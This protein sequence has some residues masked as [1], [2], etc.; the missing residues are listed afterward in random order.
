V[1]EKTLPD[2][3]EKRTVSLSEQD[4]D[5]LR[6]VLRSIDRGAVKPAQPSSPEDCEYL[7]RRAEQ[8]YQ[9]RRTRERLFGRAMFGEA[10]W[11]MLLLLYITERGP[12]QTVTR[13]VEASGF[14]KSTALRWLEYLEERR[15]VRREP[16]ATDK[17]AAFVAL[18]DQ[19]RELI[20]LYLSE[21]F[22]ASR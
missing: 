1:A 16:H 18:S 3:E 9:S 7:L 20:E 17:R 6:R 21:T 4:V 13:L 5:V 15:W 2:P 14:S 12:R 10:A 11:E 22:D 19:G 8:I